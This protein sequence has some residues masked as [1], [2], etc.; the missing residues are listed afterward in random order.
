MLQRQCDRFFRF[1]S[2]STY[3]TFHIFFH[4]NSFHFISLFRTIN[5]Y[6]ECVGI[7]CCCCCSPLV[8]NQNY[9]LAEGK[10]KLSIDSLPFVFA[11]QF[12]WCFFVVVV[13]LKQMK[14]QNYVIETK[15]IK[16]EETAS[17][18]WNEERKNYHQQSKKY[19][20]TFVP[21]LWF[22]NWFAVSV[23]SACVTEINWNEM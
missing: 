13:A 21:L 18:W 4:F 12:R 2:K 3:K 7:F 19:A 1:A 23:Q 8:T 20:L 14:Y 22:G 16:W 5:V 17:A 6:I 10:S 11:L 15:K 9:R